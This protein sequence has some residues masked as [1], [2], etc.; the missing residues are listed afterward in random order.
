MFGIFDHL[1]STAKA[2]PVAD[3]PVATTTAPQG[4]QNPIPNLPARPRPH[5]KAA[6]SRPSPIQSAE[7]GG[8]KRALNGSD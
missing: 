5:T 2:T 6:R 7:G 1:K 4:A 8:A 3:N